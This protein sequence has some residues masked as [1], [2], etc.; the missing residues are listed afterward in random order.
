MGQAKRLGPGILAAGAGLAALAGAW[1]FLSA[2]DR[3]GIASGTERATIQHVVDG[4][5]VYVL[6]DGQRTKVRLLNVDAPEIPHPGKPGECFGEDAAAYL[7]QK[8]P[9]GSEVEL[10][11]D[12]ERFDSYDRTLAGVTYKGEFVN[13]SLVAS[14]HATAMKVEP[15]D[16]FY[17]AMRAAQKKAERSNAGMYDPANGCRG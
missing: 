2:P 1:F 5:T 3:S 7:A 9:E 11:F 17:G 13:E 12:V 8:L 4:D 15:N 10:E 14:G 16:K 6:L